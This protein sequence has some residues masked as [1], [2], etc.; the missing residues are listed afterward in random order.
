M[1]GVHT[2]RRIVKVDCE[3]H[4]L[5]NDSSVRSVYTQ[6]NYHTKYR[7]L[8]KPGQTIVNYSTQAIITMYQVNIIKY[9]LL[10]VNAVRLVV[11]SH[12]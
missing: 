3:L 12:D 11:Y 10:L 2:H 7:F 5:L 1:L 8:H 9:F 6:L 4:S